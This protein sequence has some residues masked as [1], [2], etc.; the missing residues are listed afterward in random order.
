[1][2][3]V[4]YADVMNGHADDEWDERL[5]GKLRMRE[6]VAF[7]NPTSRPISKLLKAQLLS[8]EPA[9]A[10]LYLAMAPSA[11]LLGDGRTFGRWQMIMKESSRCA[12]LA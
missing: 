2:Y 3:R 1:M 9:S 10:H 6:D 7:P 5:A 4:L 8:Q 11:A 12:S